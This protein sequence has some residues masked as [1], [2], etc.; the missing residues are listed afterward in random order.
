MESDNPAHRMFWHHPPAHPTDDDEDSSPPESIL[1]DATAYLDGRTN[2]STARCVTRSGHAIALTFWI[3]SPPR[4]SYFTVH[5]PAP[6]CWPSCPASSAPTATSPSSAFCPPPPPPNPTVRRRLFLFNDLGQVGLLRRRGGLFA[7]AALSDAVPYL[8]GH[9][10][11]HLFDSMTC[12]WSTTPMRVEPTRLHGCSYS[13]RS[14]TSV[15]AVGGSSIGWVDLSNKGIL[16]CDVLRRDERGGDVLRHIR[17]PCTL[18]LHVAIGAL[19]PSSQR[20]IAVV[21]GGII[22]TYDSLDWQ[23]AIWTWTGPEKKWCLDCS[24]R[25][26]EITVDDSFSHLLPVP[27]PRSRRRGDEAMETTEPATLS[28]LHVGYPA[29]S[30]HE[31]GVVYFMAKVDHLDGEAWM[32]AVDMRNKTLEEVA[33]FSTKR[34]LALGFR[35]PC[36]QYRQSSMSKHLAGIEVEEDDSLGT[37]LTEEASWTEVSHKKKSCSRIVIHNKRLRNVYYEWD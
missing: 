37:E 14:A 36:L 32:L 24:L 9:Y 19:S 15:I 11:L 16:V 30:L 5:H 7:V 22:N 3:A 18:S 6:P 8:R 23:A 2:A 10:T 28:R 12:A 20:G 29:L 34:C 25:A 27:K 17:L 31:D 33:G 21:Q 13:Y 1:L 4:V 35:C 26:S